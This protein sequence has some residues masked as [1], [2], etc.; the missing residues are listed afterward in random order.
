MLPTKQVE[1]E[2]MYYKKNV[3]YLKVARRPSAQRNVAAY[4]AFMRLH[5]LLQ[6]HIRFQGEITSQDLSALEFLA[7][8]V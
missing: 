5:A 2:Q 3:L 6:E 1:Q 4:T 7:E 8:A